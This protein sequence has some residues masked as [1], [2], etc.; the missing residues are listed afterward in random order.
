MI[1][2]DANEESKK[3]LEEFSFTFFDSNYPSVNKSIF[4]VGDK[5]F[6][7]SHG[8]KETVSGNHIPTKDLRT[9]LRLRNT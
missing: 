1:Y 2:T 5:V 6:F 9:Y 3:I 8:T 4:Y 7:Y